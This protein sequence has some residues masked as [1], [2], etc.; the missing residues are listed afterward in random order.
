[1][2]R[3]SYHLHGHCHTR[4]G[5]TKMGYMKNRKDIGVD[6]R[7]DLAPW[8][9]VELINFINSEESKNGVLLC[10]SDQD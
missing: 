9:K 7:E 6:S 3:G 4:H 5:T 1:M 2:R 10:D 8:E